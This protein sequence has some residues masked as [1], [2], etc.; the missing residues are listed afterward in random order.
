[1]T[2][3]TATIARLNKAAEGTLPNFAAHLKK[4]DL[5][6]LRRRSRAFQDARRKTIPGAFGPERVE[7]DTEGDTAEPTPAAEDI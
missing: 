7:N 6:E 5:T 2:P 1:M 3:P 4:C